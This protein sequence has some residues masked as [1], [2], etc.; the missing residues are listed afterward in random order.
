MFSGGGQSPQLLITFQ[1]FVTGSKMLPLL[2]FSSVSTSKP[3]QTIILDPVQTTDP[4]YLGEGA[5]KVEIAVQESN[6]GS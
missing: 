4:P 6:A 5:F 1:V 2:R 3:L